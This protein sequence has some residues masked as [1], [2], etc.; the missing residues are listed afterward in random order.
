MA[1]KV[2]F[3]KKR[4]DLVIKHKDIVTVAITCVL[5]L[6]SFLLLF[7]NKNVTSA[8]MEFICSKFHSHSD[9]CLLS[10]FVETD[11]AF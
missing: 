9:G 3:K 6:G 8:Q 1:T 10:F 4:R 7:L 5:L 2:I 11:S